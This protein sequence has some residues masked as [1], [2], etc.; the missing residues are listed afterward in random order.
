MAEHARGQLSRP[1]D[2]CRFLQGSHLPDGGYYPSSW[3]CV[4]DVTH[5]EEVLTQRL[6]LKADQITK[7]TS[8]NTGLP[9]QMEP[10]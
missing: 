9:G 8:S 7:L 4:R 2:W 10:P 3:G 5:V 1:L 6:K